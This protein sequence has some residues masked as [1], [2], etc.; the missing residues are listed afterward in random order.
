[1]ISLFVSVVIFG[2]LVLVFRGSGHTTR[3]AIEGYGVAYVGGGNGLVAFRASTGI[4]IWGYTTGEPVYSR[5]TVVSGVVYFASNDKRV[6][7]LNARNGAKIWSFRTGW[8]NI[9]S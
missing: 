9:S 8:L 3:A 2:G 7:A 5:P 1:M 4:Q 6:Y